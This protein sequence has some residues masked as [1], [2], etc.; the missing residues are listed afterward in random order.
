MKMKDGGGSCGGWKVEDCREL[1]RANDTAPVPCFRFYNR[2][3]A[4]ADS[5][6]QIEQ[7]RTLLHCLLF[8]SRT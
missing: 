7:H 1:W 4:I 5:H 3:P 8:A 6:R 2:L